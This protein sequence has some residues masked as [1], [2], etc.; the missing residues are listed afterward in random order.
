MGINAFLVEAKTPEQGE[1]ITVTLTGKDLQALK[2][3][4]AG[5]K[6]PVGVEALNRIIVDK[7][8]S[9]VDEAGRLAL[10]KRLN[11]ACDHC[12]MGV[13]DRDDKNDLAGIKASLEM[14]SY[15]FLDFS[16]FSTNV[17]RRQ[18]NDVA[19]CNNIGKGSLITGHMRNGTKFYT[20]APDY[21]NLA[22]MLTTS[23]VETVDERDFVIGFNNIVGDKAIPL[24]LK[25]TL[26]QLESDEGV[27]KAKFTQAVKDIQ[28]E[29]NRLPAAAT[30]QNKENGLPA[31]KIEEPEGGHLRRF[32]TSFSPS[33]VP[34]H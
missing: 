17:H 5:K 2:N 11:A 20:Q 6:V 9:L 13:I 28:H 15:T 8:G 29:T 1:V 14:S 12:Q 21:Q 24:L 19:I 30:T 7:A 4:S 16:E 34:H 10:E 32:L 22:N 26:K 31:D 23:N 25:R 18:I 27:T 33:K 3:V